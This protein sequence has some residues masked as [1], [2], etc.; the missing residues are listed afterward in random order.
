VRQALDPHAL[1]T[2]GTSTRG[3]ARFV[4]LLDA[5]GH[6]QEVSEC[7]IGDVVFSPR[8]SDG[9]GNLRLAR[10]GS[11]IR[12]CPAGH[13]HALYRLASPQTGEVGR[14][15]F[16]VPHSSSRGATRSPARRNSVESQRF[17]ARQLFSNDS[18]QPRIAL[19][20]PVLSACLQKS[21]AETLWPLP[22]AGQRP[23]GL[24]R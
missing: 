2:A 20:Q 8:K 3:Q 10:Q 6:H 13:G 5:N 14:L 19:E 22:G 9:P 18:I 11:K 16:L 21:N 24:A 17:R 12:T 23:Q 1:L 15:L 7:C 4:R